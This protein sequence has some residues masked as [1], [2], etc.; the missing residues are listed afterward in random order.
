MCIK[1]NNLEILLKF[2]TKIFSYDLFINVHFTF[3]WRIN[4]SLNENKG[5]SFKG[6]IIKTLKNAFSH[7]LRDPMN[8]FTILAIG[9]Y[10]TFTV[11]KY[12]LFGLLKKEYMV[13][14]IK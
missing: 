5:S 8:Y 12:F 7:Y 3:A 14:L 6:L 4:N 11:L 10:V 1:K 9:L 13:L 2:L